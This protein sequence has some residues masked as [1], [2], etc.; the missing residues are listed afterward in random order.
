[1]SEID[2]SH[3]PRNLLGIIIEQ[4]Q[5]IKKLI[6]ERDQLRAEISNLVG[7]ITSDCD[8]L[9]VLQRIYS[10]DGA[11]EANRIKA[12]AAAIGFERSKL[13]VN[14]RVGPSLLGERLDGARA[15]KTIEPLTIEHQP[16]A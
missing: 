11:S 14:V 5:L 4:N 9:T 10:D 16:A 1:M 15:M 3:D 6:A 13:T 7:W 12:A 2:Q 8:A